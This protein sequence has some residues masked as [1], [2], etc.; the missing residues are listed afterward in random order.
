MIVL[1]DQLGCEHTFEQTPK[2]IVSLV[3]SQTETLFDLGLEDEIVGITQACIYP[4]HLR[5][6]KTV[7]G[8]LTKVD[9]EQIKLLQPD[10]IIVNKEETST[11]IIESIQAICPVW[12]TD[13]KTLDENIKMI[14]AFGI[15]FNKRTE[16]RKWIDKIYFGQK[17]LMDFV[18]SKPGYKAAYFVGK[19]PFLVAGDSTFIHELLTLNKFE[20]VYA[21]R[22]EKYPEVEVRKIRIQGDPELVFLSSVP[23]PFEEEDAFEIGRFTHHGK[24][25]FVDGEMFSWFG[26]HVCKAFAYFKQIHNRL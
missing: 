9:V 12:V 17:D 18:S 11:A 25:I 16:A 1:K 5:A 19:D 4:Y 26:T 15:L 20:N 21:S 22:A 14:E 10:I 23:Y 8:D 2:R 6:T 13:V 3:P 7:V 24:T